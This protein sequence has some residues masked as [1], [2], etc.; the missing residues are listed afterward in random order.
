MIHPQVQKLIKL[1][2][3]G[4]ALCDKYRADISRIMSIRAKLTDDELKQLPPNIQALPNT[5]INT[6]DFTNSPDLKNLY[7]H[8]SSF[9]D[10]WPAKVRSTLSEIPQQNLLL[11]F[12]IPFEAS[13]SATVRQQFTRHI[14]SK[15]MRITLDLYD[16]IKNRVERLPD[17]IKDCETILPPPSAQPQIIQDIPND[18]AQEIIYRLDY[19][20]RG[21]IRINGLLVHKCKLGSALDNALAMA[22]DKP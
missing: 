17:I 16:F 19:N 13:I 22:I 11:R 20:L 8:L 1:Y 9:A 6:Q 15:N 2:D 21:E 3:R 4:S 18:S 12:N 7:L 10:R 14:F 5:K